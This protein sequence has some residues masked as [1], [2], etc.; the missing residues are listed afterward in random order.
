MTSRVYPLNLSGAAKLVRANRFVAAMFAATLIFALYYGLIHPPVFV[1]ETQ[2]SI[3]GKEQ[4]T[5]STG[6]SAFLPVSGG[7]GYPK[8]SQCE[9]ISTRHRC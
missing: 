9:S 6:L 5:V 3:R 8:V 2:F 4:S 7:G 1:A